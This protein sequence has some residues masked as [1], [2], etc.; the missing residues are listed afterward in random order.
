[1]YYSRFFNC[2]FRDDDKGNDDL[3][4]KSEMERFLSQA[5]FQ[6]ILGD[7]PAHSTPLLRASAQLVVST[8]G[9]RFFTL[10]TN[11]PRLR[12]ALLGLDEVLAGLPMMTLVGG[13]I[14]PVLDH[15]SMEIHYLFTDG[16]LILVALMMLSCTNLRRRQGPCGRQ[17]RPVPTGAARST[18]QSEASHPR[19]PLW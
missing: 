1:M 13:A 16:K 17:D 7:D 8:H 15:V 6:D 10:L 3:R 18:R 2:F 4:I 12:A 14:D 19:S 11:I 5:C 9:S